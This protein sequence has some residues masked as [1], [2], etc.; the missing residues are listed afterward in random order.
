MGE[1]EPCTRKTA[2]STRYA[3]CNIVFIESDTA[4]SSNSSVKCFGHVFFKIQAPKCK[5]SS[6]AQDFARIR[7][8]HPAKLSLT[9]MFYV[10]AKQPRKDIC[11]TLDLHVDTDIHVNTKIHKRT[12][13]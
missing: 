6:Q 13:K 11:I 7:I 3:H 12:Y 10:T 2:V 9:G 8:I 4:S 5:E 1:E